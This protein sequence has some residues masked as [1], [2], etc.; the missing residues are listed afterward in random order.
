MLSLP[1]KKGGE[2]RLPFLKRKEENLISFIRKTF[3]EFERSPF[4][5]LVV[6]DGQWLPLYSFKDEDLFEGDLEGLLKVK[7]VAAK[8]F[9]K[10]LKEGI[11]DLIK[12]SLKY[13]V[14]SLFFRF[15]KFSIFVASRGEL[16]LV[17]VIDELERREKVERLEGELLKRLERLGERMGKIPY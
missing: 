2:M 12:R 16:H 17:T 9:E 3:K 7:E 10:Y 14:N 11:A 4:K 13:R 15:G 8:E 5:A 6:Y 1:V